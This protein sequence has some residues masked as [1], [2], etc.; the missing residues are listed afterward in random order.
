MGTQARLAEL[1]QASAEWAIERSTGQRQLDDAGALMAESAALFMGYAEHHWRRA[2]DA[3]DDPAAQLASLHKARVN[4]LAA[5]RLK[6]WMAGLDRY[7]VAAPPPIPAE[8]AP[9]GDLVPTL[10][11]HGCTSLNQARRIARHQ[12]GNVRPVT[13]GPLA[14]PGVAGMVAAALAGD[15]PALGMAGP[16]FRLQTADPRFDPTQPVVIN[17]YPFQP[18]TEQ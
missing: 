7:T 6:E 8:I 2:D 11:F 12:R 17:G 9:N 1:E 15:A 18:A 10:D 4:L 3:V 14:D 13:S 5:L 16:T